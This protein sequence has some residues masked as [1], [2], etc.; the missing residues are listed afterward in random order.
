MAPQTNDVALVKGSFIHDS[1]EKNHHEHNLEDYNNSDYY[2]D[3][4][5]KSTGV[6]SHPFHAT[7]LVVRLTT[8]Y[9]FIKIQYI[10]LP[11]SLSK[12]TAII[13]NSYFIVNFDN[14]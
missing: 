10:A 4:L 5:V 12:N 13:I 3:S 6:F 8:L 14:L 9:L 11:T 1:L 2:H 7:L